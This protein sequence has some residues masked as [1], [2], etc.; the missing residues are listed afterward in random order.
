MAKSQPTR[1]QWTAFEYMYKY[2]N[3]VLFAGALP[4]VI[5]NFSRHAN[6]YGFFTPERWHRGDERTHEISINPAHLASRPPRDTASTL[7]HEMA[8]LWQHMFG[9][10]PRK[11]YHDREW[12]LKMKELG[13][14]PIDPS[15]GKERMSA[16]NLKHRI[17]AGGAYDQAFA[18]MPPEYLFPWQCDEAE[19]PRRAKGAAKVAGDDEEGEEG[20]G[21]AKSKNKVKYTCPCAVN[22]WG[23]PD[24]ALQCMSCGQPFAQAA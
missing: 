7:V 21:K 6:S 16:P 22:V 5:L 17:E 23:K 10:P 4:P 9:T 24:L 18:A 2:F 15:T 12:A 14:T 19:M 13:L 11:G 8:H 3:R 20:E 1:E